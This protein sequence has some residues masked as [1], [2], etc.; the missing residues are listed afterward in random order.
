MQNSVLVVDDEKGIRFAFA[1]ALET[2]GFVVQEAETGTHALQIAKDNQID[3]ILLDMKLPDMTGIEVLKELKNA[4][5]DTPV[6]MMTAFGDIEL[7]VEA[8]QLGADN[9][10]TKPFNVMEMK[11]CIKKETHL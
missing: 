9:F 7:A 8:M 2:D 5:I 11:E 4:S 6:I 3:V 10:R 1:K